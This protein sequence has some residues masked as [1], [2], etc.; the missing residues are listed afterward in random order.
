MKV[1]ADGR[2]LDGGRCAAA[3]LKRPQHNLTSCHKPSMGVMRAVFGA[4]VAASTACAASP[5]PIITLIDCMADGH[6][7]IARPVRARV[8]GAQLVTSNDGALVVRV[9]RAGRDAVPLGSASVA[10]YRDSASFGQRPVAWTNTDSVGTAAMDP[11]AP[12]EYLLRIRAIGYG[13]HAV[14]VRT[15]A[16]FSDTVTVTAVPG[17]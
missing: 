7:E 13:S 11:V 14:R 12:A 8:S 2:A 4:V 6:M 10:L 5:Q 17:C 1:G 3:L 16:G 9:R 15:R